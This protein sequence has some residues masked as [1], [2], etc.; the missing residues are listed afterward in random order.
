LSAVRAAASGFGAEAD[1]APAAALPRRLLHFVL[2]ISVLTSSLAFIEPSPHDGLMLVLLVMCV[3]ARVP[4]DR[5]LAPLFVLLMLWLVGGCLSLI[6]VGDQQQT[7]QYV[8]TSFYLCL[9]AIMFACLFGGGDPARLSILRRGYLLAALIATAAGYIGFFHLLPGSDRFLFNDH[10]SATFKDPNVYGPFLIFPLQMLMT[11]LMTRR[12]RIGNLALAAFLLGGL[13]L[14]FSRGAWMHFAVSAAVAVAILIAATPDPRVRAR[15]LLFAAVAAVGTALL[16]A[17]MMSVDTVRDL[18]LER[19]KA[20]Q[21]YDVGP[22]GRFWEQRLALDVILDHPNGMGPF[23]PRLRHAAAR[24]LHAG[25]PGLRVAGRRRLPDPRRRHL[26][27]RARNGPRADT[28]AKLPH[29]R[30]CDLRRRGG[31]GADRRYRPLASLLP[32][33]RPDLGARC[34]DDQ[35]P[36]PRGLGAARRRRRGGALALKIKEARSARRAR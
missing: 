14:S 3:A 21:P 11:A 28:V 9:A 19:A 18:F 27:D 10:V 12:I 23:Q 20:I 2:F 33:A 25:V 15:I 5:K 31:R 26:G 4:F 35:S 6:Q 17:A 8:G 13:F 7:I 32:S 34:G 24:R 1:F 36:S 22:G 30:L 29:R 16:V